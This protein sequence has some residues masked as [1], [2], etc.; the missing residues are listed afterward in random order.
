MHSFLEIIGACAKIFKDFMPHVPLPYDR[1]NGPEF[2]E[3]LCDFLAA[4]GHGRFG[5]RVRQVQRRGRSG[6]AQGGVDILLSLE[7]G[8]TVA[9]ECKHRRDWT[10]TETSDAITKATFPADR[11]ILA[12]T[13]TND[14]AIQDVIRAQPPGKWEV[15]F[16]EDIARMFGQHLSNADGARVLTTHFGG[17]LCRDFLGF[18]EACHFL[19]APAFFAGLLDAAHTF[20]HAWPVLGRSAERRALDRFVRD[21]AQAVLVLPA[22]GGRGKSKLL[23]RFSWRFAL[24]HPGW[25]LRFM[26]AGNGIPDDLAAHLDR[27]PAGPVLLVLDDAHRVEHDLPRL[28]REVRR[29]EGRLKLICATRPQAQRVIDAALAEAEMDQS[30]VRREEELAKPNEEALTAWV[31]RQLRRMGYR[32]ELAWP[33]IQMAEGSWLL[34]TVGLRILEKEERFP[35]LDA[36]AMQ[37]FVMQKFGEL[38]SGTICRDQPKER[39]QD[40]LHLLAA[41]SPMPEGD[42]FRTRAAEFLQCRKSDIE[43]I[44]HALLDAGVLRSSRTGQRLTPDVLADHL[45]YEKCLQSPSYPQELATH[46]AG[47]NLA[48]LLRNL[49]EVERRAA[50]N[51]T[52]AA[53][54]LQPI[55]QA[56]REQFEH[57]RFYQRDKLIELWCGIAVY[58]PARFLEMARLAVDLHTE[59]DGVE[60]DEEEAAFLLNFSRHVPPRQHSDVIRRLPPALAEVADYH[61][62]HRSEAMNLLWGLAL[63]WSAHDFSNEQH[64]VAALGNIKAYTGPANQWREPDE[65]TRLAGWFGDRMTVLPSALAAGGGPKHIAG[66]LLNPFFNLV[67]DVVYQAA[68]NAHV[69][70]SAPVPVEST[71]P[72]RDIIRTLAAAWLSS[73]DSAIALAGAEVV[74]EATGDIHNMSGSQDISEA[75]RFYLPERLAALELMRAS[76]PAAHPLARWRLWTHLNRRV[77]RREGRDPISMNQTAR[78][79][80]ALAEGD[81][82]LELLRLFLSR[83][84]DEFPVNWGSGDPSAAMQYSHDR[85]ES[86]GSTFAA[87]LVESHA[88][89]DA[90]YA[91]VVPHLHAWQAQELTVWTG[92][93]IKGVQENRPDWLLPLLELMLADPAQQGDLLCGPLLYQFRRSQPG[94]H[95][96][97]MDR[98]LETLSPERPALTEAAMLDV[99]WFHRTGP[100]TSQERSWMSVCLARGGAAAAKKLVD[101]LGMV[102][103]NVVEA[104]GIA[105]AAAAL[106]G[107]SENTIFEE[108]LETLDQWKYRYEERKG[109]PQ[110]PP[111]PSVMPV[112]RELTHWP[113][114]WSDRGNAFFKFYSRLHPGDVWDFFTA[115]LEHAADEG[116]SAIPY[117][118]EFS[119]DFSRD[120]PDYETRLEG[121]LAAWEMQVDAHYMAED[122]WER[123]ISL[124]ARSGGDRFIRWLETSVDRLGSRSLIAVCGAF[125]CGSDFVFKQAPL[126]KRLL[127]RADSLGS[128]TKAEVQDALKNSIDRSGVWMETK[129]HRNHSRSMQQR[130]VECVNTT[131]MDSVLHPFY[132]QLEQHIARR[133][134]FTRWSEDDNDED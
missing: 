2:E 59:P 78:E 101:M 8:Q 40:L 19:T 83:D 81:A 44:C 99:E 29:S 1:L 104:D 4:A 88:T 106:A 26:D 42:G 71:R 89:P 13:R 50:R 117:D 85:W 23:H 65:V 36:E 30:L 58:A 53:S 121:L 6:Q 105:L 33:L 3:F 115:R 110:P 45:L 20:H 38:T 127:L 75:R 84:E 109:Q 100:L 21:P 73:R 108:S 12:L 130:A 47:E 129:E 131:R 46:F 79:I 98:V 68:R 10:D 57:A 25:S 133:R 90:L 61:E 39:V 11:Y 62:S 123:W 54:V 35:S 64:P 14:T 113:R 66:K 82:T 92:R 94:G 116:F 96:A 24:R 91:A 95:A 5:S 17:G 55:F 69:F 87:R 124:A 125:T 122:A 112:L 80:L 111:F 134:E 9:V 107:Q 119:L 27:L 86:L 22:A 63:R 74:I 103:P 132:Q 93:F 41:W 18:S 28:L 34:L 128:E 15:W 52:R 120:F 16:G 37:R 97:A 43:T 48:S 32:T 60:P 70:T 118:H 76:W 56:Q 51:N 72:A 126:V 67:Q 77:S 114:F 31:H 7:N 102:P 49:A